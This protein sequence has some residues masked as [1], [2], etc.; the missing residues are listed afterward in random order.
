[1]VFYINAETCILYL[2]DGC[3]SCIQVGACHILQTARHK[4]N[5]QK[6]LKR[7]TFQVTDSQ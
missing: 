2:S 4:G 3:C 7:C 1:M 6:H 5:L